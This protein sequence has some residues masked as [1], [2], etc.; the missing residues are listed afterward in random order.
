VQWPTTINL[1]FDDAL[2]HTA[3]LRLFYLAS[4]GFVLLLAIV[5]EPIDRILPRRNGPALVLAMAAIGLLSPAAYLRSEGLAKITSDPINLAME[6]S[7]ARSFSEL[8]RGAGCKLWYDMPAT[9]NLPGF[10]D[11]IAKAALPMGHRGLD[12]LVLSDPMPWQAIVGPKGATPE[13]LYPMQSRTMPNGKEIGRRAVG[14]L[15]AV[16]LKPLDPQDQ[17]NRLCA[18]IRLRWD[19]KSFVTSD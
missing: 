14:P 8:A 11:H 2:S 5:A 3:N 10:A 1:G 13:A 7:L 19:G 4:A 6:A 12:S 9:V 18:P 16:Y 17:A 15:Y